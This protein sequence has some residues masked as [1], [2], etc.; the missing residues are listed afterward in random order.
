ME[1]YKPADRLKRIISYLLDVMPIIILVYII[2]YYFV[3][4]YKQAFDD[5]FANPRGDMNEY[6]EFLKYRNYVR[7]F[8]LVTW[9]IYSLIMDALPLQGTFAKRLFGLQVVDSYGNKLTFRKS[10]VRNFAK[11]VGTLPLC[12]GMF[13]IFFDKYNRPL[14]DKLS[15]TFVVEL[16]DNAMYDS[17]ALNQHI[18]ERRQQLK[19][20]QA[21]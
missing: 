17:N 19:T 10:A 4:S 6:S 20:N 9:S 11:V 2:T 13:W 5:Y 14:H 15:G 7:D 8:S 3:P 16:D 12:L 1:Y 21:V 18:I